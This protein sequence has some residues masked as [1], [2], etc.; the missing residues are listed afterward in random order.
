MYSQALLRIRILRVFRVYSGVFSRSSTFKNTDRIQ[1][2][3]FAQILHFRNT[4]EYRVFPKIFRIQQNTEQNTA[5]Y[6]S[7]FSVQ[8][9]ADV[10][11]CFFY[12]GLVCVSYW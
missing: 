8:E 4:A 7:N 12:F 11:Y 3:I 10:V 9:V 5:E 6:S 1:K 2:G